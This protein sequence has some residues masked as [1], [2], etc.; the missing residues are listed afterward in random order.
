MTFYGKSAAERDIWIVPGSLIDVVDGDTIDMTVDLGFS[1]TKEV[2]VRLLGVDTAEIYGVERGSEEYSRGM[3]HKRFVEEWVATG[4]ADS[5][6][7]EYPFDLFIAKD[8]GKY[9]RFL[10]EVRRLSDDRS[11]T[12]DLLAEFG[13]EVE[14]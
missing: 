4:V 13:D 8:T 6:T 2:R 5:E 14:Y 7:E 3:A 12:A 11:L 1:L 10:A 9:G